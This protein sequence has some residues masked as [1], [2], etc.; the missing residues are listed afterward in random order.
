MVWPT[1]SVG[2]AAD[3]RHGTLAFE[4]EAFIAGDFQ[5]HDGGAHVIERVP[6][7]EHAD[8]RADGAGCVVV[9]GLA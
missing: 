3:L 5:L 7:I 8:E 1:S 9:L 2:I 4:P 6:A